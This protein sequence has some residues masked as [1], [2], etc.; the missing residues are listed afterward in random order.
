MTDTFPAFQISPV[1]VPIPGAVAPEHFRG[2]YGM[3]MFVTLPTAD[4]AAS[5]AFWT[6]GLGFFDLFSVPARLTHLR[7]WAFQDVL[8]VPGVP[9]T[10]TPAS[11][12]SFSCVLGEVDAIADACER[13][14][15]GS[16]TGP[17]ETPWNTIELE[18]RT[19]EN[20]R[21]VMTA[22]RPFDPAGPQAAF[23]REMGIEAP[24]R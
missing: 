20:T 5:V 11:T 2:I 12:V 10:G 15:P 21:V 7:R 4:F 23:L 22:A 18:V 13:V 16:T 1:P 24:R 17:R 6:D 3:P 19:P 14:A 9:A 8:L